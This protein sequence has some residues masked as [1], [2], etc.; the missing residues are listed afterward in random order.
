MTGQMLRT[1]DPGHPARVTNVELFFDLVFVFAVTQLSHGLLAHLN[2][3]G[4]LQAMILMLAV[5]WAW[6][7]TAWVTNWLNPDHLIV[8]G[9]LFVLMGLGLVLSTSAPEAFDSRAV[10]FALA[11]VTFQVGR[12]L[13]MVWAGRSD[14]AMRLN[15]VRIS[16]WLIAS[17]VFWIIGAYLDSDLRLGAWSVALLIEYLGP[18]TAFWTLGLGRTPTRHWDV[19]GAHM[20]ERCG[21]FIIICLGESVV[22]TGAAFATGP[23]EPAQVGAFVA[24]LAGAIAMWWIYFNAHADAA[25]EAIGRAAD[26]GRMAR[27]AYTYAHVPLVAGII[28]TAAGDELAVGHPLRAIVPASLALIVGGPAIFLAGGVWFKHSVF[29]VI[30]PPRVGGLALLALVALASPQLTALTLSAAVSLVLAVVAAWE[31]VSR[32]QGAAEHQV[33]V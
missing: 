30:S 32:P 11:Y 2:L 8:R 25:A 12:S 24:E 29:K 14:Q 28:A 3:D 9:L 23:W 6:V 31:T 15:F 27:H 10:P 1:R 22:M 26:P 33:K 20:A 7:Y 17:G 4:A 16:I 19:E 21:L 18:A 13:F 5:W